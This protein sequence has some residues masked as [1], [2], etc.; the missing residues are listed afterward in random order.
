MHVAGPTLAGFPQPSQSPKPPYP[1]LEPSSRQ[2]LPERC[3]PCGT[4]QRSSQVLSTR[5]RAFDARFGRLQTQ[6]LGSATLGL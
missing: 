3:G 5:A 6:V 4:G 1:L 2:A